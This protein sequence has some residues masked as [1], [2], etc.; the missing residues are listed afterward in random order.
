MKNKIFI[1]GTD[2]EVGKTFVT[3]LLAKGFCKLGRTVL[4]Q[5]WV[6]TGNTEVSE[7]LKYHAEIMGQPLNPALYKC[8]NPYLF[9][10]AASP[11]LAARLDGKSIDIN[12]LAE[13]TEHLSDMADIL[14]IEGAGGLLV[15]LAERVLT[16]DVVKAVSASV[17]VVAD[18]KLGCVNHI[19]LTLN[20]LK[21][22]NIEVLGIIFNR[23]GLDT[24]LTEF[25]LADNIDIVK[26]ISGVP[27]FGEVLE[28]ATEAKSICEEILEELGW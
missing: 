4:T 26:K 12:V 28:H 18:N 5:K 8:Q 27:V 3:A 1:T 2:T 25:A 21:S 13:S 10:L 15:P 22:Y 19:L 9:S 11:H 16:A 6:E 23:T 17:L 7:D 14:L 24:K 20:A